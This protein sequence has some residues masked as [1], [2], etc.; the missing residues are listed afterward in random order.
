VKRVIHLCLQ[1]KDQGIGE[2]NERKRGEAMTIIIKNKTEA[3]KKGS[4][5]VASEFRVEYILEKV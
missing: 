1:S 5:R 2:E 4:E 3:N